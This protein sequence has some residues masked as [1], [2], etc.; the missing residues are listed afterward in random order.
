LAGRTITRRFSPFLVSSTGATQPSWT[1]ADAQM[2]LSSLMADCM[3][4]RR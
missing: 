1:T 4:S 3:S 2:A